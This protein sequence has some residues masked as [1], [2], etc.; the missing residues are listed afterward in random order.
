MWG[1]YRLTRSLDGSILLIIKPVPSLLQKNSKAKP[2]LFTCKLAIQSTTKLATMQF[3]VSVASLLVLLSVATAA[4]AEEKRQGN[5]ASGSEAFCLA[6]PNTLQYYRR[7]HLRHP[8]LLQWTRMH[9]EQ[10][11]A[12]ISA[13]LSLPFWVVSAVSRLAQLQMLAAK[14]STHY[15]TYSLNIPKRRTCTSTDG[16]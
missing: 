14:V 9:G 10:L 5:L 12:R 8:S 1:L 2:T 4:P 7:F 13:N 16:W 6:F 3:P 15:F 11:T